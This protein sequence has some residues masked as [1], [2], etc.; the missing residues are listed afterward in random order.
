MSAPLGSNVL[1]GSPKVYWYA[2]AEPPGM[3][4]GCRKRPS[5]GMYERTPIAMVPLGSSVESAS[6]PSHEYLGGVLVVGTPNSLVSLVESSFVS[7]SLSEAVA[8]ISPWRLVSWST[9]AAP[10][11]WTA[12][13]PPLIPE[14]LR[15]QLPDGVSIVHA[16][17]LPLPE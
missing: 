7:V 17:A 1:T 16:G 8:M 5:S 12:T 3:G 6:A 11:F 13:S 10:L 4:S 9:G 14:M 2:L 15:V